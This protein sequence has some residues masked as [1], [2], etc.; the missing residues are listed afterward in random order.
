M[1][2]VEASKHPIEIKKKIYYFEPSLENKTEQ[3]QYETQHKKEILEKLFQKAKR[4][5]MKPIISVIGDA[6]INSDDPEYFL[7]EEVGKQLVDAGYRVQTGGL[8]GVMEAA[9]KG[10]KKSNKYEY[11]DTLAILPGNDTSEANE[12]ADIRIATGL[13]SMR[14]KQVVDAYAVIAIGGG[15]GT[16]AEIATAWSMYKLIIAWNKNGWSA[17]LANKKVD[18]RQ[19]YGDSRDDKVYSFE[20]A[21]EAIELISELGSKYQKEYKGIKWRESK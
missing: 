10:A 7:A 21:N 3:A 9:L 19:R 2:I 6:A 20:S 11:G 18:E 5:F 14:A 16:L 13:D 12:F 4:R 15:A 8:G 17:K 1:P